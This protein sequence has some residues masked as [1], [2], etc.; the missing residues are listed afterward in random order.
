M[1]RSIGDGLR[2]LSRSL[3]IWEQAAAPPCSMAAGAGSTT[4]APLLSLSAMYSRLA[5][6]SGACD[7][8]ISPSTPLG[9]AAHLPGPQPS[10]SPAQQSR[11]S[12]T[13]AQQQ[14]SRQQSQRRPPMARP[15]TAP[16]MQSGIVH[17]QATRNN[18]MITLTDEAG[19]TKAWWVLHP[20][21]SCAAR[22]QGHIRSCSRS[23]EFVYIQTIM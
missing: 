9:A 15:A 4:A 10:A 23:S 2:S 18:T 21:A 17:I 8:I 7:A 16:P 20:L 13:S 12:A 3:G 14:G 22:S 5:A 6:S 19:N 11:G 1:R